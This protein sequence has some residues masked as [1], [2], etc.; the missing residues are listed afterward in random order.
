MKVLLCSPLGGVAGGIS[1]WTEKVLTYYS[2]LNNCGIVLSHFNTVRKHYVDTDQ[3]KF[4]RFFYGTYDSIKEICRFKKYIG[5]NSFDVIHFTSSGSVGLLPL[6]LLIN[7]AKKKHIKVVVHFR[8]GRI[9]EVFEKENWEYKLL[10]KVIKHSDAIIVLDKKSLDTIKNS[11]FANVSLCPNPI[12]SEIVDYITS[13]HIK[14]EPRKVVFAGHIIPS[15]GVMELIHVSS[16]IS[17]MS[18]LLVGWYSQAI[19]EEIHKY[20]IDKR[21]ADRVRLIGQ[22]TSKETIE[23]MLSSE[24]FVLPS[25][26]EGFP[27]VVSEAM[28][29]GCSIIATNVGAIPEMLDEGTDNQCGYLIRPKNEDDLYDAIHRLLGDE[30]LRNRYGS[31]AQK[32]AFQEYT[33]DR[34]WAQ[35]VEIW[36]NA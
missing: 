34:V 31:L 36:R 21:I 3:S 17:N 15:K 1:R 5:N 13:S 33:M 30:E 23:E 35:M 14:R 24:L 29:C 32:K 25:Y 7:N 22:K 26:T 18:L 4:R 10:V 9:P 19:N 2:T 16:R 8:F 20:L 27:N 12:S 6:S 11:G 28:A